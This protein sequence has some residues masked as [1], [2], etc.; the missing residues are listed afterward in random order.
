MAGA[1]STSVGYLPQ[2]WED[3]GLWKEGQRSAYSLR[4][5]LILLFVDADYLVYGQAT[6]GGCSLGLCK[7][8][9]WPVPASPTL[10][11]LER[12]SCLLSA[13]DCSYQRVVRGRP[14]CWFLW[15]LMNPPD[16]NSPITGNLPF[17][18]ELTAAMYCLSSS[19][20]G[21]VS[22]QDLAQACKLP[23]ALNHW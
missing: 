10:H 2:K 1:D 4:T 18:R 9:A 14:L 16:V 19:V 15:W 5:L 11:S 6:Q 22:L 13:S 8:T 23:H 12:P 7:S 21:G 20:H 3:N 17:P